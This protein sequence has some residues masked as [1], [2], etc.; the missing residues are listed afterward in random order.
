MK[1]MLAITATASIRTNTAKEAFV[2]P[3]TVSNVL[4]FAILFV[5]Y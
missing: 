3:C 2:E 5:V 4:K 1:L